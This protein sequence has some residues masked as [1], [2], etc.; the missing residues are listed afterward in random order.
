[1]RFLFSILVVGYHLQ[2][3]MN[4]TSAELFENGA[5]AVEFFFLIS[6]Y[7]LAASVEKLCKQ[8]YA[9]PKVTGDFM[10]GKLKGILPVHVVATL[11]NEVGLARC[12]PSPTGSVLARDLSKCTYYPRMVLVRH[13]PRHAFYVS[14]HAIVPTHGDGLLFYIFSHGHCPC[15][16][17]QP[18]AVYGF[19][20]R[21]RLHWHDRDLFG[22]RCPATKR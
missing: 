10:R 19:D 1:M 9:I 6:G 13:A 17:L 5:I 2:M 4:N 16:F 7:F 14:R 15:S 18:T 3:S 22:Q 8:E 12:F 11:T 21:H 20:N